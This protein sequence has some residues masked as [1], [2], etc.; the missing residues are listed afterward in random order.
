MF[1]MLKGYWQ[2]IVDQKKVIC[3]ITIMGC[4]TKSILKV[5]MNLHGFTLLAL[6]LAFVQLQKIDCN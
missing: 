6:M 2:P 4:P 5:I 1:S 3:F